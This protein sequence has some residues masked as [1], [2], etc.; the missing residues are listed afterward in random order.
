MQKLEEAAEN[1][2]TPGTEEAVTAKCDTQA[3]L[4]MG[5]QVSASLAGLRVLTR[6]NGTWAKQ[7]RPAGSDS[8]RPHLPLTAFPIHPRISQSTVS[9]DGRCGQ[10]PLNPGRHIDTSQHTA[11]GGASD[12]CILY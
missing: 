1:G 3:W 7:P 9:L 4:Q 8:G 11:I 2:H 10:P 5:L 6:Q 12:A